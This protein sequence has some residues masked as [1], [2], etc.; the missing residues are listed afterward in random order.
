LDN[1]LSNYEAHNDTNEWNNFLISSTNLDKW[2]DLQR[3][4]LTSVPEGKILDAI[5]VAYDDY[6]AAAKHFGVEKA[7]ANEAESWGNFKAVEK[8]SKRLLDL[9]YKLANA[10]QDSLSRFIATSQHSLSLLKT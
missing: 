5:N 10:H 9:G 4:T 2:I 8:E 1:R 6:L 7:T 3:P